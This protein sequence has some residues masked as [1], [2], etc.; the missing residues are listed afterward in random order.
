MTYVKKTGRVNEID[1]RTVKKFSHLI[2]TVNRI[3]ST[4]PNH[5]NLGKSLHSKS[6]RRRKLKG[7]R[8][9]SLIEL[10][11]SNDFIIVKH[12]L[13]SVKKQIQMDPERY[14]S[15][16]L[17]PELHKHLKKISFSG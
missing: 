6:S 9:N 2:S 1:V 4:D 12:Q 14:E 11:G 13:Q 10:V 8:V 16:V 15:L 5:A 17:P 3:I 7:F